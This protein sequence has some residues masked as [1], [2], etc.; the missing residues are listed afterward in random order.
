MT[1]Q[2]SNKFE[3]LG[4][5]EEEEERRAGTT[6]PNPNLLPPSKQVSAAA[7]KLGNWSQLRKG[8]KLKNGKRYVALLG[9]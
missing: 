6:S 8:E 4:C 9:W 2:T 7:C 1:T 5:V 3:V